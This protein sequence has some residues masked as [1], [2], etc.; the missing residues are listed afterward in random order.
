MLERMDLFFENKLSGYD[1]HMLTAIEGADEFC[2]YTA[3][4][5]PKGDDTVILDLGCGTG[6]ELETYFICNP[7]AA[8]TGIDLSKSMLGALAANSRTKN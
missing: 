1:E 8:V 6:L 7:N 4:L 5:L 3:A 2:K